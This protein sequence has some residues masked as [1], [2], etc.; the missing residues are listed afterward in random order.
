MPGKVLDV[1]IS[2]RTS[3]VQAFKFWECI[4]NFIPL[5]SIKNDFKYLRHGSVKDDS[6]C[7]SVGLFPEN[8]SS[9]KKSSF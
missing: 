5:S 6:K 4:S 8:N 3:T 7:K 1:I 2:F 9:H